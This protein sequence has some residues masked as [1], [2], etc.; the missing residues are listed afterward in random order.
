[1]Q[2]LNIKNKEVAAL[3][4]EYTEIFG[5][6]DAAYYVLSENNGYGLDKAPNG[7]DSKLFSDLLAHYNGDKNKAILAKS[8]VYTDSF[9]NW[10]GD[11]LN[12]GS[13]IDYNFFEEYVD[14][15]TTN[16]KLIRILLDNYVN[17]SDISE[18]VYRRF[19]TSGKYIADTK[20]LA[21][22]VNE[23]EP[24]HTR[25]KVVA[26]EL[27]HV[28]TSK[29]CDAYI[30]L[31][32]GL[33]NYSASDSYIKNLPKLTEEQIK[34]FDRLSEIKQQ[35]VDYLNNNP[36]EVDRI[37]KK[38][39]D[40]FGV[41]SYFTI[42]PENYNLHEFLSEAF[43]NPALIE[44]MSQIRTKDNK[45]SIFD[46]FVNALSKIF[47]FDISSTLF[48]ET[49]NEVSKILR[50]K[51]NVSKVV[52]ENGEPKVM[53]RTDYKEKVI[54]GRN[55]GEPFFATDSLLVAATY[56]SEDGD[57]YT[58]FV[59]LKNPYV[60][61]EESHGFSL[62]YDRKQTDIFKIYK[63][64]AKN[65]YDGVLYK[66]VWDVG[67]NVDYDPEISYWASNVAMFDPNQIKSIDNQG[68]FST[69]DNNIY[70]Q[71]A[72]SQ[73][74]T[75]R[76]EELAR[77][78]QTLYPKIEVGTLT[79]PN[80]RGQAHVEGNMAGKVLLNAVLENQDTLP[81][82]YAHHYI[83]WFR[84]APIVQNGI[85]QFGS[86]E[87]LVQAIGENSVKATKWYNRFFNWIKGLFNKK[88]ATLN[89][90]TNNFL[91]GRDLQYVNNTQYRV[92]NQTV[93][94]I[95]NQIHKV[96][97]DIMT[98]IERRISDFKYSKFSNDQENEL[99]RLQFQMNQFENDKAVF[100]FVDYMARDVYEAL[101]RVNTLLFKVREDLKYN[102]PISA[103][104]AELDLIKKGYI[105]FYGNIATNIQNMLDDQ[106][107][108]TYINDPKLIEEVKQSLNKT[109]SNYYEL[110]RNYNNVVDIIAKENFIAE[111]SKAG[112][113][114]IDELRQKLEE[115]DKDINLWNQW[116]GSTQY[117]DSE[118]VRL[119]LNKIAT[120]KNKV[121][122]EELIKG[123]H[124]T[125]LLSKVDKSKLSLLHEKNKKGHK[126]GFMTRDL[127]YGEHYEMYLAHQR[128]LADDLGF[129]DKEVSEVP[130]LLNAEQLKIW[131]KANNDWDAKYTIRKFTPEYYEL[132]NSLSE[133]ARS[134]RDE[135][136]MEINLLLRPTVDESGDYHREDLSD[137][138][139]LKLQELEARRRNLAN[140]FYTDGTVKVG[141]DK[142]I[143][144]EIREYN[145][146]LRDKLHYEPNMEKFNKARKK[147]KENL[148]AEKYAKWV[149]RNTVEQIV[150]EFWEDVK[151][152]SSVQVKSEDQ[153]LYEEARRNLLRLYM[154]EDGTV[155]VDSM[156]DQAK[157][158]INTYDSMI[159]QERM[160][161]KE[162][163]VKSRVM[164]IAEWEIN[165]KYYAE[166]E[167]AENAG[168]AAFNAWA[169]LNT[170]VDGKGNIVPASFWKR[171]VPKK[172]LRSKY[173]RR[174]PNRSWSEIDKESPFY[175]KRFTKYVGRGET[176]IPNPKYFDNSSNYNKI[177]S[178]KN[179]KALYDALVDTYAEANSEI[180]F[181]RYSNNYKLAQ[182]E[183]GAWTQIMA[184]D[185]ILKGLGYAI[186]DS[187]TVKD[188]DNMYMLENAKR[189]DGS[190][191]KL[192][193]TRYIKM[194]SDPNTLTNDIVG[195]T[196]AYY[197]MAKNY[198]EMS[199]IAPELEIALDFVSR[200]NFTNNKGGRIE[201]IE[202]KTYD[203][204][205]DT[206]NRLVYGMERDAAE[207]DINL[208]FSDKQ[209]RVSLDKFVS[210]VAAYTRIQGISQNLNVI[211]TGLIT[212]KIQIRLEAMSGIYF[213]NKELAQA[214]KI[215]MPSYVYALKNIGKSNNKD[216]VLCYLEYLGIVRENSQTFSKL[217]QS[218][219]LRALN[220][221][222]W[223][224]GHEM[225]D[226]ITKGKLAIAI[227]LYY[228]YDPELNKFVN[229]HEFLRRF[230][231]K[232]EGKAKWNTLT[233]T[234]FDA[235]EVENNVLV[236]KKKY[237]KALDEVTINKI[238][239]TAK[240]VGTRIDTQITDLDKSKLHSTLIGQLLLIYRNFILVNLQ[241]KFLTK[242]QFNYSTG[243]W[244]E[245]QW[246]AAINAIKTIYYHY[247][248]PDKINQLRELYKDH[249]DELTEYEKG[250]LKRVTY[251]VLF[252]TLGFFIISSILRSM[253]DDD[254]RNWWKQES[255]YLALRASLETRGNILPIEVINM[256]NT[257]T[258]AWTTLQGL[259]DMCA[260]IMEDGS[261]EV[262]RG[263]YK[264]MTRFER[265][266]I[267][268]TPL[269]S[270]W[271]ARDP[272]SKMEYYDNMISIFNF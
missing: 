123:K 112:S 107:T 16:G 41:V 83:A 102:N 202:S 206:I 259:F 200:M 133:D 135:I 38:Y 131:N 184:K 172:E 65:G 222:F 193:P 20:Q 158:L 258:A 191:V 29:Y 25:R 249:Y 204:L 256:L 177:I 182:I 224:F 54:M 60:V 238:K 176:R 251:E 125:D 1:M 105:G 24:L 143:A 28:A 215:L 12:V 137:E 199:E 70:N 19:G 119:I 18:I 270:I 252:S 178:D 95:P 32:D 68:T 171:L 175:D 263:P 247:Y 267:K 138:D 118:I 155:D 232:K 7:A 23:S 74:G 8:K 43:T 210:N 117:S 22:P 272:R 99:R 234:F 254:K 40:A 248:N 163:G 207:F 108:F 146:K 86:E 242:R 245:A 145:K 250:C 33:I 152:L 45:L 239:N 17:P 97:E 49:V 96:Y 226:Y 124:L 271:E 62:T 87:S 84:N 173:T 109:I 57:L 211:L 127:N 219:L 213:S 26:H 174:V 149:Q 156:P 71:Q 55:D 76:N 128:K 130:G 61:D 13:N 261:E 126:T 162:E 56:A 44:V 262:V 170:T 148:S 81:H 233:T 63:T 78:L 85:K 98:G 253:A 58:G 50:N 141:L 100:E 194:L 69:Q 30:Y 47:G 209:F 188:D 221:H 14:D 67:D 111:A 243:M 230:K 196:I 106:D 75:G 197:K 214:T 104:P 205:K 114:T 159:Y 240:Q 27:M 122:E 35:V 168:E 180:S 166:F 228:K 4:K 144:D 229:K 113:F 161:N 198:K 82:E 150:E 31:K 73:T 154:R 192:V 237:Q 66:R 164:E 142:K 186:A 269:R 21:I 36:E 89:T 231:N 195:S 121:A 136:N 94:E 37:R 120:A 217:N 218:R 187:W 3:L 48:G 190:L 139:Y 147:A 77:L 34:S 268:I 157:D 179:L 80:L 53:F 90:L 189:S 116:V 244:S 129:A 220:Q 39:G 88:Q 201:G 216:K 264:G 132:T 151:K 59:N 169:A 265:S 115:G 183:G 10:F 51:S 260:T 79:D 5:N 6:E 225:T 203:K 64:L 52:D 9:K 103:S 91:K 153:I 160:M 140:P 72:Q 165:P 110:V 266:L 92:Y 93:N 227:G 246:P 236:P 208:P 223:Y 11:W 235:F 185:N 257:P 241:T 181:M 2:C 101:D 255:A 134:R 42:D 46:K 212:N 167:K 15:N